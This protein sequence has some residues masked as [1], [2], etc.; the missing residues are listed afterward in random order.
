MNKVILSGRIT[1]DPEIRYTQNGASVVSFSIAVD[2]PIR[3]A[4]G[5]RQADFIN[6]VAWRSTAEFISRYIKKGYMLLVEGY[7]TSRSYQGQDGQTRY[8]TEVVCD[9]VEN[10]QPR[11]PSQS[12][13]FAQPQ[14]QTMPSYQGFNNPTY[15]AQAPQQSYQQPTSFDVNVADDD[16]PF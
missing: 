8:V 15:G 4:Q 9:N 10:L 5:N 14:P 13:G 11:D 6:C 2:R 3:D 7:I 12:Q 16:L 1:K